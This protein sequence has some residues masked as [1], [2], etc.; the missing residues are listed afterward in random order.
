MAFILFK[1]CDPRIPYRTPPPFIPLFSV[2][3]HLH[4]FLS[5][6]QSSLS[7]HKPRGSTI[8]DSAPNIVDRLYFKD[9]L[10]FSIPK[11]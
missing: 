10:T 5:L 2:H 3:T 1:F 4:T 8:C 9:H 11:L 6:T 7:I